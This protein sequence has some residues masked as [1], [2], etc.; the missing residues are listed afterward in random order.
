MESTNE[1]RFI[2]YA[3]QLGMG[4]LIKKER[5]DKL[6]GILQTIQDLQTDNIYYGTGIEF[7]PYYTLEQFENT[8]ITTVDSKPISQKYIIQLNI[9]NFINGINQYIKS[10]G[11]DEQ[12]EIEVVFNGYSD[13]EFKMFDRIKKIKEYDL[14][15]KIFSNKEHKCFEIGFDYSDYGRFE[16]IPS[17]K[18]NE[19]DESDE[20][21]E[22]N[23][24]F[25]EFYESARFNELSSTVNMDNYYFYCPEETKFKEF[26]EKFTFETLVIFFAFLN[27]KYSLAKIIYHKTTQITKITKKESEHLSRILHYMKE[28]QFDFELFYNK[29]DYVDKKGKIMS[30]EKFIGYL[31]ENFDLKII[32]EPGTTLCD[33]KYFGQIINVL[34]INSSNIILLY[35]KLYTRSL[36]LLVEASDEIIR[37]TNKNNQTKDKF[38]EYIQINFR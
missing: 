22:P 34:D 37:L 14:V 9:C 25:D 38:A 18:L 24:S 2:N 26:F 16:Y 21:D 17:N 23:K 7:Q 30:M 35:R 36:N 31:E 32:F 15:I 10:N 12:I 5:N 8:S 6:N 11:L 20:S 19:L 28:G 29:L 27:D 4:Q 1:I 33:T 3:R 13:N